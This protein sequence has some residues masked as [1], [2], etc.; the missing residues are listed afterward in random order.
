MPSTSVKKFNRTKL[1]LLSPLALGIIGSALV[2]M[3]EHK[4]HRSIASIEPYQAHGLM[5]GKQAAAMTIEIVGPE[6][7]PESNTEVV[8]LVGFITQY[9]SADTP[10]S[11]E[12]SLPAGVELVRG[13]QADTLANISL[14]KAQQVSILVKGFSR[15]AQKLISLKTQITTSNMPLTASAVVVSRPEETMEAR[16]MDLQAQA[17][18][19]AEEAKEKDSETK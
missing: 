13:P 7:Y 3:Q 11:Y 17:K 15:D 1:I 18:A 9:L 6:S 10:L 5:I 2:Y 16:V 4:V 19:A 14:G 12:W 8:E